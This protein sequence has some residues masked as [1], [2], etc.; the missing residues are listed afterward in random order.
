V[1]AAR[2]HTPEELPWWRRE[3]DLV[4]AAVAALALLSGWMA[5]RAGAPALAWGACYAVSF[6][7]AGWEP[8][9]EGLRAL[10]R[11]RL[12]IDFLML[13]AAAGAAVIGEF[14]EGAMLLVLFA[15]GHGLEHYAMGQARKA[16]RAL[17]RLTPTSA[18]VRRGDGFAEVPVS[19]VAAGDVVRVRP[20]ERVPMDG[21]VSAG[22]SS[23]DQSP[24]T[25]ES[26][27]VEKSVG[28]EVF[29]GTLNGD[30]LIEVRVTRVAADS[31][32]AR[33]IR[34]VE[35]AQGQKS[36]TQRYAER[37]TRIY[38]PAV[39]AATVAIPAR[40]DASRR[41]IAVRARHQHAGGGACGRGTC[42]TQRRPHQGRSAPRDA[43]VGL[44]LRHGQ[45]RDADRGAACAPAH[46]GV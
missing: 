46:G 39:I 18:W 24:I 3:R 31:T 33:M 9:L 40:H 35:E 43:G 20:A 37:F 29:A 10:L 6:A 30:G 32:V 16:I 38:V 4:A 7:A 34:L 11:G 36:T 22:S 5:Q 12:D 13:A 8:A 14:A 2:R 21:A 42:G 1:S 19:A 27:P 26:V 44:L 25:G 15:L 17:G 45:D 28:D 41:R 23:I